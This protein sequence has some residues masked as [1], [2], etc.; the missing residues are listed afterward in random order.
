[1][2]KY[3][4]PAF[5]LQNL[6]TPRFPA[7]NS[8]L[9]MLSPTASNESYETPLCSTPSPSLQT[10]HDDNHIRCKNVHPMQLTQENGIMMM[11]LYKV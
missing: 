1:M 5:N 10:Y 7:L 6:P 8:S 11:R 9:P 3:D 4:Q 2:E